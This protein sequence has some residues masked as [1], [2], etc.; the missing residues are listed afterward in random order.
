MRNKLPDKRF[1][2]NLPITHITTLQKEISLIITVGYNENREIKEVFCADFKAG[3]DNHAVVMDS[4]ILLSRL[5]QHGDTP[6]QLLESMCLPLSL[7]GTICAALVK[8]EES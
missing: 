3:S 1:S 7:I 8:E 4:C 6:K 2:V 5:L